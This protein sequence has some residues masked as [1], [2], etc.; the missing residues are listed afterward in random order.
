MHALQFGFEAGLS[1]L[2][3]QRD[4]AESEL[5]VEKEKCSMLRRELLLRTEDDP[6]RR[7]SDDEKTRSL[8]IQLVQLQVMFTAL[9]CVLALL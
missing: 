9:S 4:R 2:R 3:Q 1:D 6:D 5:S 7:G 8:L